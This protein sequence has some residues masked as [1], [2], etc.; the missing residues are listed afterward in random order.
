MKKT[1]IEFW[2]KELSTDPVQYKP[3]SPVFSPVEDVIVQIPINSEGIE[4]RVDEGGKPV[5]V[6]NLEGFKSLLV[7][8]A[9]GVEAAHKIR[10]DRKVANNGRY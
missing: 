8:L 5:V 7:T 1:M 6:L 4:E 2:L 3:Y 9:D 10:V